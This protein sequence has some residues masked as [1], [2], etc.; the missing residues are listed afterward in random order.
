M[1]YGIISDFPKFPQYANPAKRLESFEKWPEHIPITKESMVEAGLTY[2]G[3]GDSVRC[4][5][6]GGGLRNF[7]YGEVPMEEHAKWYP[8]CPHILLLK[9]QAFVDACFRGEKPSEKHR[10]TSQENVDFMSTTAAQ[11]CLEYNYSETDIRKAIHR[12]M[13]QFGNTDF[14][15]RDLCKILME[16]A[17]ESSSDENQDTSGD[18]DLSKNIDEGATAG[19]TQGDD[20]I[21]KQDENR[22]L[23][24][25]MTCKICFDSEADIVFLPCGHL[26]S[27]AMCSPALRKCPMCRVL[28]KGRIKVFRS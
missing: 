6:C 8:R 4:Y 14:R 5:Y 22:Q 11:V 26:T 21:S 28:V 27:C 20:I 3:V 13:D 24:E 19:D 1:E 10:N 7:E 15:A 23:K 9:G 12:Y 17:D 18:E 16:M 25:N 2:T